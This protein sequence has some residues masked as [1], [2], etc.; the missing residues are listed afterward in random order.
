MNKPIPS[1]NEEL[2]LIRF[3]F[4]H[5]LGVPENKIKEAVILVSIHNG[6]EDVFKQITNLNYNSEYYKKPIFH[7]LDYSIPIIY[8]T[9]AFLNS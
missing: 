9:M 1:Y 6:M 5:I 8:P 7:L 4:D 2:D 3:S